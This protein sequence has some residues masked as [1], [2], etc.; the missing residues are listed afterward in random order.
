MSKPIWGAYEY[1][2]R[3]RTARASTY[4]Q[5]PSVLGRLRRPD[6]FEL[7]PDCMIAKHVVE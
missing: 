1:I 7:P 3:G 2:A 5:R 4:P 6:G